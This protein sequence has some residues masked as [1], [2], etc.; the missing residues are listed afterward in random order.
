M[1]TRL[2][3]DRGGSKYA[4]ARLNCVRDELKSIAKTRR[5]V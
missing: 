1:A 5:F 2:H 4:M 3:P